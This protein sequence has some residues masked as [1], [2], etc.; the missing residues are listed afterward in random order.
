MTEYKNQKNAWFDRK[1]TKWWIYNVLL[2][3]HDKLR[4]YGVSCGIIIYKLSDHKLAE[5]DAQALER[6]CF[7]SVFPANITSKRQPT[8]LGIIVCLKVGHKTIILGKLLDIFNA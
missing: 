6:S 2:P 5:Q 8:D 4:V 1:I 3:F 7:N